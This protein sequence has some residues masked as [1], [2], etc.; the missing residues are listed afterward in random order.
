MPLLSLLKKN[1]GFRLTLLGLNELLPV[2]GWRAFCPQGLAFIYA[3]TVTLWSV[4]F[5][6]KRPPPTFSNSFNTAPFVSNRTILSRC[7]GPT[8]LLRHPGK[9]EQWN[10]FCRAKS[11]T[12]ARAGK[13]CI[14]QLKSRSKDHRILGHFLANIVPQE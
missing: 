4:T 10:G 6:S 3:K 11:V 9:M 13:S 12:A 7:L 1:L 2:T 8:C 5:A 14:C